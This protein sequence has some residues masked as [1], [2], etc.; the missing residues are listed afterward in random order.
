MDNRQ[1][2]K[3]TE[4]TA[5]EAKTSNVLQWPSHS[6]DIEHTERAFHLLQIQLKAEVPTNK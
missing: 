2:P 1:I 6:A 4:K 5:P 3:G